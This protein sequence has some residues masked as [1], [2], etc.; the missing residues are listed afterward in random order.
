M[1]VVGSQHVNNSQVNDSFFPTVN[2]RLLKVVLTSFLIVFNFIHGALM[3]HVP[4]S[5]EIRHGVDLQE[6]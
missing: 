2:A 1:S 6:D 4:L 3:G 5:D